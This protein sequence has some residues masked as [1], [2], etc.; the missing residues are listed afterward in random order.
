M[1][2]LLGEG[3]QLEEQPDRKFL[4]RRLTISERA[5]VNTKAGTGTA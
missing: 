2:L 4:G 3:S 5:D 1:M